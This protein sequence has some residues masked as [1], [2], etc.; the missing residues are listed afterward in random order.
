[1]VLIRME[2]KI[3]KQNSLNTVPMTVIKELLG[4][5]KHLETGE[6]ISERVS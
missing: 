1:M 3:V 6:V 2:L 5:R 4:K